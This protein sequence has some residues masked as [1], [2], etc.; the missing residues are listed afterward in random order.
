MFGILIVFTKEVVFPFFQNKGADLT[1]S[2][3]LKKPEFTI[4]TK[5]NYLARLYTNYGLVTID[6]YESSA[7][8]NVN[9]FVHLANSG[10]FNATKFH[11]LIP[12]FLLQGGDRNTIDQD[13]SNDGKGR[14]NYLIDDEVNWDSLDLPQSQRNKLQNAGFSSKGGLESKPLERFS[15]AMAN[16]GPNT[17]GSQFF[18]VLADLDDPRLSDFQGF[19]T[20]IGKVTGGT[21]VLDAISQV[22]VDGSSR[23]SKDIVIDKAEIFTR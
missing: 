19:F 20:V 13:L 10:Y 14:P 12:D 11:R 9:S 8:Q 1:L 3:N 2:S 16:S 21:D 23:P 18:I 4:D 7:P 6:L 15:V 5:I 17:N 22:S